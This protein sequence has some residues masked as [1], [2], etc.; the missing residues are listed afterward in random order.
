M[1]SSKLIHLNERM[2]TGGTSTSGDFTVTMNEDLTL[3]DGDQITIK[4]AFI[5]AIGGSSEDT[6]VINPPGI[7]VNIELGYYL[8]N[9]VQPP[10]TD[11]GLPIDNPEY[12]SPR[13][14]EF[15]DDDASQPELCQPDLKHYVLC[16]VRDENPVEPG[17]ILE[18]VTNYIGGTTSVPGFNKDFSITFSWVDA[19]GAKQHKVVDVQSYATS[20]YTPSPGPVVSQEDLK[21]YVNINNYAVNVT[22]RLG[23]LT[24]DPAPGGAKWSDDEMQLIR[25]DRET[26]NSEK[27]VLTPYTEIVKIAIPPSNYDPQQLAQLIT[28]GLAN[29]QPIDQLYTVD[30]AGQRVD[31]FLTDAQP[32]MSQ[33]LRTN[34]KFRP[35]YIDG[36]R[37]GDLPPQ[38]KDEN[39]SPPPDYS[40][41]IDI[42]YMFISADGIVD[43]QGNVTQKPSNAAFY[44]RNDA[45]G[46]YPNLV[47]GTDTGDGNNTHD[48]TPTGT[49][50][51]ASNKYFIGCPEP[52]LSYGAVN[53]VNKFNWSNLCMPIYDPTVDQPTP[54]VQAAPVP[55]PVPTKPD[56]KSPEFRMCGSMGGVYIA[57]LTQDKIDDDN[58]NAG[59]GF[60]TDYCGFKTNT[61]SPVYTY[62]DVD[63][64]NG[65]N[66]LVDDPAYKLEAHV[67]VFDEKDFRHK[68]TEYFLGVETAMNFEPDSKTKLN[69]PYLVP[70]FHVS[71]KQ[72]TQV[73][74]MQPVFAS[75]NYVASQMNRNAFYQISMDMFGT[76]I[77]NTR[78]KKKV[79]AIISKYYSTVDN[80]VGSQGGDSVVYE[81]H[82]SPLNLRTIRTRI[83]ND[84]GAL[85]PEVGNKSHVI[86]QINRATQPPSKQN[87]QPPPT[88]V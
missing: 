58:P 72:Q 57:S 19:S 33:V 84:T 4:N 8:Q 83:L 31:A 88:L 21:K 22:C 20:G 75:D 60:W 6:V 64:G 63:I 47:E 46:E 73:T 23:S 11:A 54:M 76:S 12:L 30:E 17:P 26:L 34:A 49:Y 70:P 79:M 18:H 28:D 13:T 55:G 43:E 38:P 61:Y 24:L 52:E 77:N 3:Y 86:L 78:S 48:W 68:T 45:T 36:Y 37:N 71:S 51:R 41:L 39:G 35:S 2:H 65:S 50:N 5:D 27:K 14:L 25:I 59:L 15:V 81:H 66:G 82:G 10:V 62:T 9:A 32:T 53:G 69:N 7:T 67:P 42:P 56:W 44:C 80:Y 29:R 16:S 40:A 85:D 87:P 74:Q 1:Q